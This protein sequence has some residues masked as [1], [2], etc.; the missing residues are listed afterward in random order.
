M[1]ILH[2]SRSMGQGGA[3]KIVYQLCMDNHSCEQVVI[4]AG[5]YYVQELESIGIKHYII[6]DMDKKNPILIFSTLKKIMTVVKKEKID[7]IH[8]HHRMAAFYAR[9]VSIMTKTPTVY[10]SH[11]I[12]NDKKLLMKFSLKKSVIVAVGD[13]V[14]QNLINEYGIKENDIV[15][16]KN[17]IVVQKSEYIDDYLTKMKS[18]G[19]ILIG[20]IGRLSQ[21]KA[22][23]I[24]LH[25][26][27][28]C[29]ESHPDIIAVVIGDG[30]KREELQILVKELDI[31]NDVYFMGYQKNV[32][33]IIERL[34]FVVSTSQREGLPLNPIEVFSQGKTIIASN[35]SGNNE[36]ITDGVNG[37][38]CEKDNIEEFAEKMH[39]LISHP[40]V[41]DRLEK[42]ALNTYLKEYDYKLFIDKYMGIYENLEKGKA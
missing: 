9:I 33:D 31:V 10:T 21:Q 17:T 3:Q 23:D 8:T 22:I 2:I 5:G 4:S 18:E 32:L 19:K 34:D 29:K 27:K 39:Y 7:V 6:P 26:I 30:E 15:V 40:D 25:C 14:K 28:K 24:F 42:N 38:L 20:I 41:R 36:V 11:S 35:I 12:F 37:L 16:I 13:G 1:K